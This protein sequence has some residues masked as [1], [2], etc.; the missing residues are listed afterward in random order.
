[1]EVRKNK[2]SSKYS[3]YDQR[4]SSDLGKI[5]KKERPQRR[6]S[7]VGYLTVNPH[8][9]SV[10]SRDRM[11]HTASF[12]SLD[13]DATALENDVDGSSEFTG[14]LSNQKNRRNAVIEKRPGELYQR[15]TYYVIKRNLAELFEC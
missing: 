14:F 12:D 6:S 3:K 4:R 1:M 10:K 11:K 7:D 15:L 2:D 5:M 8:P 9:R 13:N